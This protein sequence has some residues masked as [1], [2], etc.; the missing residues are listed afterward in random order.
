M[1][2][3]FTSRFDEVASLLRRPVILVEV[4]LLEERLEVVVRE[5]DVLS[6]HRLVR[7]EQLHHLVDLV[8]LARRVPRGRGA[9]SDLAAALSTPFFAKPIAL[10]RVASSS[11]RRS[12]WS[13]TYGRGGLRVDRRVRQLLEV[14][15]TALSS[16]RCP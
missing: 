9:R 15:A 8:P 12:P 4:A 1:A 6:H 7:L 3:C 2:N 16:T 10:S 11:S 13:A 14:A 5:A